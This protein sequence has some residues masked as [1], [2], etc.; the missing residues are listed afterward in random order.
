MLKAPQTKTFNYAL[1]KQKHIQFKQNFISTFL[2]SFSFT[3]MQNNYNL[4]RFHEIAKE[5]KRR[6]GKGENERKKKKLTAIQQQSMYV[7]TTTI[8]HI[9]RLILTQPFNLFLSSLFFSFSYRQQQK[10]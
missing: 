9:F 1:Y 10:K 4:S 6:R 8:V 3:N 7:K 2:V 5:L